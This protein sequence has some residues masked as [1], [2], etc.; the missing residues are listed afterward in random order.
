M[1]KLRVLSGREVLHILHEFGF[2]E[3]AQRGSHIKVRRVLGDGRTQ[4]LTVPN[5]DEIDR[6]TLHAIYRQACRFIPDSE[7]R[8]AFYT[9]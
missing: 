8:T 2:Q 6:G 4:S 7:L 3:F 1:P 5:Y 9:D